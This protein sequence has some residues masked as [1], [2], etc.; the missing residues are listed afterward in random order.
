MIESPPTLQHDVYI[1]RFVRI[2]SVFTSPV[3]IAPLVVAVG[4]YIIPASAGLWLL[5]QVP[6][7]MVGMS[8]TGNGFMGTVGILNLENSCIQVEDLH[9]LNHE[10]GLTG[11]NNQCQPTLIHD[12]LYNH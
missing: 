10:H 3:I 6:G 1:N 4:I 8:R 9:Y 2:C 7:K 12:S 11:P 5:P